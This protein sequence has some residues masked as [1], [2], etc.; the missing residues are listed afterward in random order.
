MKLHLKKFL[1]VCAVLHGFSGYE[2]HAQQDA[3]AKAEQLF[4]KEQFSKSKALFEAHLAKH[5]ND[6]KAQEYLGDI[7]GYEKR[8]DDAIAIYGQLVDADQDQANY[9]F[10]LGGSL[11]M[12][13]LSISRIRALSYIGDIKEH[14]T[15]AVELDPKHIEARWALV[16]FYIQLPG[17]VGGSERKALEYADQLETISKVDGFLA[18]G[19]VAEYMDRPEDAERYYKKA[20]AVGG[21]EHTYEKLAAHYEKQQQPDKAISTTQES[22]QKH[23]RNHLN[24]QIGKIAAQYNLKNELGID[25]LERYIANHSVRD[26]VPL[27]WAYYR[28]AQIYKNLGQKKEALVWIDKALSKR[29]DFEE[30]QDEKRLIEAL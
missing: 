13:A 3:F 11:G 12:K 4:Q 16:E 8:W 24:Y 5:P 1:F 21:S 20:I 10:K 22:L 7:A 29:P 9:H 25:C 17:I 15:R 19:Y 23:Q 26:G 30:A 28:L 6:M 27:D 14:F 18:K 2:S